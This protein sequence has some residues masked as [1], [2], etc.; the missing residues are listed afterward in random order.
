MSGERDSCER[1]SRERM[2]ESRERKERRV[3]TINCVSE[4]NRIIIIIFFKGEFY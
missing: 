1:V 4:R 3:R 2:R